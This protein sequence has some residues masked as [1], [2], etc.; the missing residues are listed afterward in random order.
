MTTTDAL[1]DRCVV[2]SRA[3]LVAATV[4][5]VT[6]AAA[7]VAPGTATRSLLY[8]GLMIGVGLPH[9]GFE[10]A[11]NLRGRT[12]RFQLRYVGAYVVVLIAAIGAFFAAPVVGLAAAV[13]VVTLKSGHGGLRA[14]AARAGLG[15]LRT[16]LQRGLAVF[17]RGGAVMAVP[18]VAHPGAFAS[19]SVRMVALFG[20]SPSA[21]APAFRPG[22][23][24]AVAGVF[25]AAVAVHLARSRGSV[26]GTEAR[27][28][29]FDALETALL[30][31]FFAVVPP[32]L[33]VGLYFPAW[34]A[35]RQTARYLTAGER[36][37]IDWRA[38]LRSTVRRAGP[39]W[40]GALAAFGATALSAPVA[41]AGPVDWVALYSAVVSAVAVPHV[42]VGS[43]LDRRRGIWSAA[44]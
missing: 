28:F 9:G 38:D 44:A 24:T 10:H 12:G 11:V 43:W 27:G 37:R 42:A 18:F 2:G 40:L 17:V 4:G 19:V 36:R 20:G 13:A 21:L 30:V 8:L 7:G 33:A 14:L 41:P 3:A 34:Y 15:H 32:I 31:G 39:P 23:R 29:R 22:V 25:G 16:R 35:T 5:Y 6:A 26:A 1:A